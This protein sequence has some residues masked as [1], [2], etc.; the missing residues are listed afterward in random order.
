YQG[1]VGLWGATVTYAMVPEPSTM[2]LVVFGLLILLFAS[3]RR[4]SIIRNISIRNL[5]IAH[6]II[7]LAVSTQASVYAATI[8]TMGTFTPES[9][10]ST[11]L[12]NLGQFVG[13]LPDAYGQPYVG[14]AAIWQN[15]STGDLGGSFNPSAI[16]D[17]GEV[18]RATAE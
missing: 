18:N 9:R 8:A 17:V 12:N 14:D 5:A 13:N 10:S 16:S 2:I 3:W 7:D 11:I 4:R 15:G 1:E 6:S